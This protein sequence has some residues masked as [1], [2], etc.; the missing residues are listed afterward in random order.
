MGQ[1][2]LDLQSHDPRP[3]SVAMLGWAQ[4]LGTVTSSLPDEEQPVLT[5][6]LILNTDEKIMEKGQSI[7][8]T[9]PIKYD[10]NETHRDQEF[11]R[12]KDSLPAWEN[13]REFI[14]KLDGSRLLIIQP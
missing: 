3:A 5:K 9:L 2:S 11:K 8:S 12:P 10:V 6:P 1:E 13:R 4:G 14:E 7:D